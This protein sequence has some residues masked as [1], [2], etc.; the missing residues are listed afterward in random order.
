MDYPKKGGLE[1]GTGNSLI[2]GYTWMPIN[3]T[4]MRPLLTKREAQMYFGPKGV[5]VLDKNGPILV[6]TVALE[7][8]YK[9]FP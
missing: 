5:E 2:Y 4:R 7:E 3:P 8:E 1:S 6:V 9:L